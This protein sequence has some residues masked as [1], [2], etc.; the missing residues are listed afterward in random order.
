M[1]KKSFRLGGDEY[2]VSKS[3]VERKM[4][5]VPPRPIGKYQVLVNG[6]LYPPKQ[7]VAESLEKEL[8]AFTTMDATRILSAV[9]FE[10]QRSGEQSQPIKNESEVLFEQYLEVAGLPDFHYQQ[11]FPGKTRR[12]DYVVRPHGLD[13]LVF[14]VKEFQTTI[15]DFRLAGGAFDP[16]KRI[17]EKIR[18]ASD[19]LRE[20]KE[21]CCSLVLFNR[22]KPLV[23]LSWRVVY[24]A[25][26]GNLGFRIP[27]DPETGVAGEKGSQEI[28]MGGG[29][30]VRYR[31]PQP[32]EPQ[33]QTISSIVVLDMF[34]L[35]DK[36]FKSYVRQVERELRRELTWED[37]IQLAN[38]CRGTDRDITLRQLRVV[39]HENPDARMRLPQELFCGPYDERF[40]RDEQGRIGRLFAGPEILKIEETGTNL[41]D[42]I[43]FPG[44]KGRHLSPQRVECQGREFEVVQVGANGTYVR[45]VRCAVCGREV[46]A[47]D[48]RVLDWSI[49]PEK[50]PLVS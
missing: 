12:P 23:V 8:V 30:M 10:V 26:L 36:R 15:D 41:G 32:L 19:Q 42:A 13:D 18:Q 48:R 1:D 17:R 14:E 2:R 25:M 4:R 31:G 50:R 20:F 3:D 33:K 24:G 39:V 21:F 5:D 46:S 45:R 37:Q 47:T 34:P 38:E 29:S 11:E 6:V 9:G 49:I 43:Q 27:F 40:G 7:V 28:F 22:E 16:Y 35:G 44:Q